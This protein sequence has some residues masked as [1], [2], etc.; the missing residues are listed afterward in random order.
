MGMWGTQLASPAPLAKNTAATAI[1]L[2]VWDGI[3]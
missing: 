2:R 1:R 3:V